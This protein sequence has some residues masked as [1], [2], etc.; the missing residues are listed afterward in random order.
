MLRGTL[1][2]GATGASA[3]AAAGCGSTLGQGFTGG[4]PEPSRL[5]FWNPFTGGDG[6]RML[7]MQE[8]FRT[9]HRSVDLRSATFL[10]GNPITRS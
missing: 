1:A 5:N 2:L 7:A 8:F 9:T 10:W 3:L 4:A 6:E